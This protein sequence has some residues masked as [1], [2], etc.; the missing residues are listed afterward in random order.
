MMAVRFESKATSLSASPSNAAHT[1]PT[2]MTSRL[3]LDMGDLSLKM[4]EVGC[5]G[6][7]IAAVMFPHDMLGVLGIVRG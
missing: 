3:K 5:K 7:E 1:W 4:C 2:S 6:V